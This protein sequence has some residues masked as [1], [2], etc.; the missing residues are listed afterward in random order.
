MDS[1]QKQLAEKL[2]DTCSLLC[3]AGERHWIS[4]MSQSLAQIENGNSAG[5]VKLL[6]AYGGMG[7]FNDLVLSSSD[8]RFL[9]DAE[10]QQLNQSLDTLRSE[11]FAL[12]TELVRQENMQSDA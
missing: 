8:G 12:A 1:K 5:I 4:W 2:R 3:A 6:S 11:L 7:S 9:E 10:C